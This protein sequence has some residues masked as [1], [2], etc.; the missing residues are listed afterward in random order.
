MTRIVFVGAVRFSLHCLRQV[1]QAG[2]DVRG[3][4]S[5]H[6]DEAKAHADYVDI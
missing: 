6:P 4:F 3:V 1:I 2:G 5:L